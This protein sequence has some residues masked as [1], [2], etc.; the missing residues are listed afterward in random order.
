MYDLASRHGEYFCMTALMLAVAVGLSA[1]SLI[2]DIG[3]NDYPTWAVKKNASA[4]SVVR[5]VIDPQGKPIECTTLSEIGDPQ[6][7][8]A[9]C[10]IVTQKRYRP[11]M[12]RNGQNVRAILDTLITF[13]IP[14]TDEGKKIGALRQVPDAELTVNRLPKNEQADVS[15]ILAF[16][17]EGRVT[18]CAPSENEKLLSLANLACDQRALFDNALQR[19]QSGQL[20]AYVT[21][22]KIRFIPSTPSR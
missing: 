9:V 12:L 20:I 19:D 11:A 5:V 7:A 8:R 13:F 18:D 22:K 1:P 21:R 16:D 14:D 10:G 4:A 6:L 3:P 15:V 17:T 2:K